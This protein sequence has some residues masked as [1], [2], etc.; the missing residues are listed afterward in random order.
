LVN[1]SI[2]IL[3]ELKPE[4]IKHANKAI[5]HLASVLVDSDYVLVE[6]SDDLFTFEN[7]DVLTDEDQIGTPIS[8]LAAQLIL[9]LID[10]NTEVD[11][12]IF[13]I[14]LS[15]ISDDDRENNKQMRIVLAKCIERLSKRYAKNMA[16]DT[17]VLS[18]LQLQASLNRS[19]CYDISVYMEVTY[20]RVLC[21]LA[22]VSTRPLDDIHLENLSSLEIYESLKVNEHDF[23]HEINTN[24]LKILRFEAAK[25]EFSDDLFQLLNDAIVSKKYA[26]V[27]LEILE[28]FTS[29]KNGGKKIPVSTL[30]LLESILFSNS[31]FSGAALFIIQNVIVN[32]Q[33]VTHRVL[34]MLVDWL[35]GSSNSRRRLRV[36]KLLEK[37][38]QTQML[39]DDIFLHLEL[40]RAGFGLQ[41]FSLE[42][43]PSI[44]EFLVKETKRGSLLPIDTMLALEQLVSEPEVLVILLNCT[45]NKQILDN[46]L[47]NKLAA[48]YNPGAAAKTS[49][50]MYLL[51]IF[52]NIER[53][54]Q[55]LSSELLEK[56]ENSFLLKENVIP[57]DQQRILTSIFVLRAQKDENLSP[58][59]ISK[60]LNMLEDSFD[61]QLLLSALRSIIKTSAEYHKDQLTR[62]LMRCLIESRNSSVQKLCIDAWQALLSVIQVDEACLDCLVDAAVNQQ[63]QSIRKPLN[64]LLNQQKLNEIQ[65]ARI[66]LSNV[67]SND[68]LLDKLKLYNNQ[69]LMKESYAQLAEILDNEDD[70]KR[71]RV[72]EMLEPHSEITNEIIFESIAVLF[73]SS[74]S[75]EIKKLCM[76]LLKKRTTTQTQ[77]TRQILFQEESTTKRGVEFDK[78]FPA[79]KQSLFELVRSLD[80]TILE[81][82]R[83]VQTLMQVVVEQ[84]LRDYYKNEAFVFLIEQNLFEKI[85]SRLA[86]FLY[87][88]I[89]KEKK[90]SEQLSVIIEHLVEQ[91]DLVDPCDLVECICRA[92][93]LTNLSDK[94]V[95]FLVANLSSNDELIRWWC[96]KTLRSLKKSLPLFEQFCQEKIKC[97]VDI[98]MIDESLKNE[99]VNLD[100]LEVLLSLRSLDLNLDS[101]KLNHGRF[102]WLRELIVGDL[103]SIYEAT[104]SEQVNFYTHWLK[105]ESKTKLKSLHFLMSLRHAEFESMQDLNESIYFMRE[106]AFYDHEEVF[107]PG[108]Y[109]V[110]ENLMHL[111]CGQMIKQRLK[112][113]NTISTDYVA[114]LSHLICYRFSGNVRFI[115]KFF[116]KLTT[117]ANVR[118]IEDFIDF[119]T[120]NNVSENDLAFLDGVDEVSEFSRFIELKRICQKIP[121]KTN[122]KRFLLNRMLFVM[123]KK[124]HWSNPQ[125]SELVEE[126][127]KSSPH[128]LID[129]LQVIYQYELFHTK[130][131]DVISN[132]LARFFKNFNIKSFT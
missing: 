2:V 4:S 68:D 8:L 132:I 113:P 52:A 19:S 42:L 87:I 39:P 65:R 114:Q 58:L 45:S 41:T 21:V 38:S 69:S 117:I 47:L 10:E 93:S 64:S 81:T 112:S 126:I 82:I 54:N 75:R 79:C 74:C 57:M 106:L 49:Y 62:I 6:Q 100:T 37:A 9:K 94:C 108:D 78:K 110:H 31:R 13:K 119:C 125:L 102:V 72:L 33:V 27:A 30:E 67:K 1:Y 101:T 103:F 28:I 7:A 5:N 11:K 61:D 15:K 91:Y 80:D 92:T 18:Q 96:F 95:E 84:G 131:S 121:A 63:D 83:D 115:A 44:I 53:N 36:F 14:L 24:I 3:N 122:E 56:I 85:P 73:D 130:F 40:V 23:A 76:G 34:K 48:A 16:D 70:S 88:R 118:A 59:V 12:K 109:D 124:L 105:I 51:S 86:L 90:C 97:L 35:Y 123:S 116:E 60:L 104:G 32:G 98:K 46:D 29:T 22:A 107:Q 26:E 20:V 43:R 111:W 120:M 127:Q 25:N 129:I 128:N 50:E 99:E 66:E 71:V 55:S 17:H 77:R 89:V